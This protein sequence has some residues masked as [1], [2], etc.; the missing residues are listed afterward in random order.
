MITSNSYIDLS[1]NRVYNYDD[2]TPVP[3]IHYFR[4]T[5]WN[6]KHRLFTG[7]IDHRPNS[8]RGRVIDE[9][10]IKFSQNFDQT[11]WVKM[12]GTT[13]HGTN[14]LFTLD[15]L[16]K[17]TDKMYI[18]GDEWTRAAYLIL[19]HPLSTAVIVPVD[20]YGSPLG[21]EDQFFS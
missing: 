1:R 16:F 10:F 21:S 3:L 9:Y 4:N 2:G 13:I 18:A 6:E 17:V 11:E 8:Y 14:G 15:P 5:K 7:I 12:R 20:K 19:D